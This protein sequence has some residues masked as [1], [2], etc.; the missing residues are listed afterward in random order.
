MTATLQGEIRIKTNSIEEA[1]ETINRLSSSLEKVGSKKNLDRVDK[2][3]K[4]AQQSS[5]RYAKELSGLNK[6]KRQAST[7]TKGLGNE[8]TK[9]NTKMKGSG[10]STNAFNKQMQDMSSSVQLALGPLSGV[11]SRITALTALFRRNAVSVA[12]LTAAFTGFAVSLS[13]TLSI[14]REAERQL[15]ALD[16][17]IEFLGLSAITSSRQMNE[18]AT[19][20]GGATL[21]SAQEVRQAQSMLLE[22]RNIGVESFEDVILTSQGMAQTFGGSLSSSIR[23]FGR[24]LDDPVSNFDALS[25]QGIRFNDEQR[26]MIESLVR[27]GRL[28]EAQTIILD[29][30]AS[31]KERATNE[32]GGLSG[33]LNSLGDNVAMAAER[34]FFMGGVSDNAS[35]AVRTLS[36]A[37]AEFA[38]SEQAVALSEAFGKTLAGVANAIGFLLD[39]LNVL[40]PIITG[41]MVGGILRAGTALIGYAVNIRRTTQQVGGMA[42]AFTAYRAAQDS[43]TAAAAR[44][45]LV[46]RGLRVAIR[47]LIPGVGI[48]IAALEMF[49]LINIFSPSQ[50]T[51]LDNLQRELSKS[52]EEME[53][54]IDASRQ[55]VELEHRAN[56]LEEQEA[57]VKRL[58]E[59][60]EEARKQRDQLRRPMGGMAGPD[61][62]NASKQ[63]EEY[64]QSLYHL[65]IDIEDYTERLKEAREQRDESAESLREEAGEL[66][67]NRKA[68]EDATDSLK[69]AYRASRQ[70]TD[71]EGSRIDAINEQIAANK[72]L[73]S[74]HKDKD[75]LDQEL[76]TNLE[77]E[78][79]LLVKRVQE[80][81]KNSRENRERERDLQRL[82]KI[83]AELNEQQ[84]RARVFLARAN[85]QLTEAQLETELSLI[86]QRKEIERNVVTIGNLTTESQAALAASLGLDEALIEQIRS[87]DD[88]AKFAKILAEAYVQEA[89]GATRAERAARRLSEARDLGRQ[90]TSEF[91]PM[92]AA[93]QDY[94][95]QMKTLYG[96]GDDDEYNRLLGLLD[97]R[98][99]QIREQIERNQ[100]REL[101]DTMT[102]RPLSDHD[103]LERDF[104]DR[105]AI[106]KRRFKEESDEFKKHKADLEGAFSSEQML[107]NFSQNADAAVNVLGGAMETM[108]AMGRDNTRF[109][110]TMA[111]I[112]SAISQALAISQMWADPNVPAWGKAGMAA[113]A[114]AAVGAQ[115]ASIRS[116]NFNQGGFVSGRGSGKSDSIPARL[117]NGEFVLQKSA[118]DSLGMGFLQR[119]NKEGVGAFNVGGAV[120]TTYVDR[121]VANTSSPDV[122]IQIINQGGSD[123]EVERTERT[124]SSD[125]RVNM[126]LFVKQAVQELASTGD[127]DGTML[128]NFGQ[129]RVPTRR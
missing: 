41:I 90:L 42:A 98:Y 10:N 86:A 8:L 43:A 45:T 53:G 78:N 92:A 117:S 108:Q 116:K 9:T 14:G 64:N 12:A 79:E 68:L 62:A 11:A 129:R 109:Y 85:N 57:E 26:E 124:M 1:V 38:D 34:M 126:K 47:T 84:E 27:S 101:E 56:I 40:A 89:V 15:M 25:R 95:E 28:M 20:L 97:R 49:G 21:S 100:A 65:N 22:F 36:N 73:I 122:N 80:M 60:L 125:G 5:N 3:F 76:I 59:S 17:Q 104:E 120:G 110:Q 52:T 114:G 66:S 128:S 77:N 88:S 55:F 103:Q 123:I 69:N 63:L 83:Q 54:L 93:E 113:M 46:L 18:M 61:A 118:V 30:F 13:K 102:F 111:V 71:S 105:L 16:G 96:I 115:L 31:M 127:L 2:E 4:K 35:E 7:N 99:A 29:R 70:Y 82:G 94:F 51:E 107:L 50:E 44:S 74:Q 24:L 19:R 81:R 67:R 39:H 87:A 33:E 58:S 32:T 37:V 23:R 75:D 48:A 72:D 119:L 121:P 106:L 6:V 112:Q 91:D